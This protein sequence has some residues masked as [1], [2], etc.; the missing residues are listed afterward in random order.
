[1]PV[2]ILDSQRGILG[3]LESTS[4]TYLAPT[5]A[6]FLQTTG[7]KAATNESEKK[8]IKLDGLMRPQTKNFASKKHRKLPAFG[9]PLSWPGA[10][11]TASSNLLAC[12][13]FM[14]ACGASAPALVAATTVAPIVPAH[15]RYTE[16]DDAGATKSLSISERL[17]RSATQHYERR[18]SNSRGIQKFSWKMGEVPKFEFEFWGSWE[19]QTQVAAITPT[20]GVQLT[21]IAQPSSAI[22]TVGALLGTK[23]LCLS[24]ISDDNQWRMKVAIIESLCGTGPKHDLVD[25]SALDVTFKIPDIAATAEFNPDL[26]WGGD[27]PFEFTIK[28][29]GTLAARSLRFSWALVNVEQVDEIAVDGYVYKKAKLTKLAPLVLQ[30][31]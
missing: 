19:E 8:S 25:D 26:Y 28:G 9:V 22:N 29:D 11:P 14:E 21:N 20:V 2:D 5:A 6:A 27:Y 23:A 7:L 24:E 1:M 15:V 16:L 30:H 10:A 13:P 17:R 12:S 18:M 3:V 31:F 4:G